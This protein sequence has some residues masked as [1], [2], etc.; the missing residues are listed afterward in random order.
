[1]NSGADLGSVETGLRLRFRDRR[2]IESKVIL[3]YLW[4]VDVLLIS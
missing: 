2:A 3:A 1:M 4:Q